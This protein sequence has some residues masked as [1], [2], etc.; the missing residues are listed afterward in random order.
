MITPKDIMWASFQQTEG[1]FFRGSK[2]I[3]LPANPS[4]DDKRVY[5]LSAT[6][7]PISAVNMYDQCIVSCSAIQLCEK[8]YLVSNLLAYVI[9]QCGQDVV[10][11]ALKPAL[12]A[13]N[14]TFKSNVKGYWRFFFNDSRGEV[15]SS[16]LQ[17]QLFLGCNGKVGSWTPEAKT[18]AKLWAACLANVWE[19]DDACKAQVDYIKKQLMS[20][21]FADSKTILWDGT[22]DVGLTGAM[23]AAYISFAANNPTRAHDALV[24][25]V[26]ETKEDKWSYNWCVQLLQKMTFL[27]GVK[28]YPIRYNAIRPVLERLWFNVTLPKTAVELKAWMSPSP[29]I[30]PPITP[31]PIVEIKPVAP[32]EETK[33]T[34]EVPVVPPIAVEQPVI[35]TPTLPVEEAIVPV[36]S[37]KT[38]FDF[39]IGLIKFL[40]SLF[41]KKS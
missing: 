13:S 6:E 4:E 16:G 17:Q 29:I 31:T 35:K 11:N 27:S 18:H 28:I 26:K 9:K 33:T 24:A 10:L 41:G 25:H 12:D 38:I 5:V 19:S 30:Q 22:P 20:F 23:R 7:G 2:H 1:P 39:I 8:F 14:A 21:V 36:T 3:Q 37:T 40:I 32:V 15:N 34:P